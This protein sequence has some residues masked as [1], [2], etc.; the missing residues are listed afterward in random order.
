M[1][2]H[3]TYDRRDQVFLKVDVRILGHLNT[4]LWMVL[5]PSWMYLWV[6]G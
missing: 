3:E 2:V 6:S 5:C 4:T 1:S